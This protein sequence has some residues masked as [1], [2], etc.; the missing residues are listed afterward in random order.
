MLVTIAGKTYLMLLPSI[1]KAGQNVV[2]NTGTA[3]AYHYA[4]YDLQGRTVQQQQVN[5]G[6]K[7]AINTSTLSAGTYVVKIMTAN[8][9]VAQAKFIVE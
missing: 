9:H 2:I 6:D 8:G 3:D 1:A 4:V 5:S 7:A